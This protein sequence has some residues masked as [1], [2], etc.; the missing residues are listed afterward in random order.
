MLLPREG[1]ARVASRGCW[2]VAEGVERHVGGGVVVRGVGAVA[3][4]AGA[5]A[6]AARAAHRPL[7]H[8][9]RVPRGQDALQVTFIDHFF[10]I[11]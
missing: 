9:L 4:A 2:G 11:K 7:R 10:N 6:G 5:A 3:G 8:Q 1:I